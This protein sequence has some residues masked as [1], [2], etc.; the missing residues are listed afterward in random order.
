MNSYHIKT[1]HIA[2]MG[3]CLAL[4]LILSY[5]ESL[6]PFNFGIPGVKLGLANLCV[7]VLFYICGPKEALIVDI[8][9]VILSGFIFGNMSMILYSLT[10]AAVS[11]ICMYT[12][13]KSDWFSPIG[14][15]LT[16]GVTHNI[17][18][19]IVAVFILGTVRIVYYIPILII[20]GALT[21]GLIG[22]ISHLVVPAVKRI[23]ASSSD[24]V[25]PNAL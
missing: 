21:G 18:Q 19:L 4:A 24:I 1:T 6:I 2:Y 10:G 23:K 14:V 22:F 11:Y 13:F 15:S 20:S 9:R 25:P 12:A 7:V 16:G 3:L 17:G 8:L 5:V